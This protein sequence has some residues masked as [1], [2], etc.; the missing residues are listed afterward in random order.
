MK[1]LPV[2]LVMLL[3]AATACSTPRDAPPV[4]PAGA[5][6]VPTMVQVGSAASATV[7]LVREDQVTSGWIDVDP[8]VAWLHLPAVYALIGFERDV[9]AEYVPEARRVTVSQRRARRLA[10]ERPSRYLDC[11]HSLTS[12]RADQGQ[13]QIF[14]S[15]WLLPENGGTTVVTRF[16][17]SAQNAGTSTGAVSCSSN[18]RL[19]R[20]IA[21]Q[22]LLRAVLEG[23][24][25]PRGT[26]R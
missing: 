9:L 14:L 7:D 6:R 13:T 4:G 5:A 24:G 23:E 19:E 3:L 26:P 12:P 1:I 17:A 16:E 8:D 18:G 10:E 20:L 21:Q 22:L 25:D 11:G 2:P 15:T